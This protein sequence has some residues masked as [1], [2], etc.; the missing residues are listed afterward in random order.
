MADVS[1]PGDNPLRASP[2][3]ASVSSPALQDLLDGAEERHF[4]AGAVM[5]RQGGPGDGLLI[6]LDGQAHATLR[7]RDGDHLLARFD[8]GAVVGEMALVTREA[9]SADV[10][11][12]SAVRAMFVPAVT[13]DQLAA[14]H[15]ELAT[16]L[17]RLVSDRLGHG[18]RDGFGDKSIEG[19]RILRCLGRGGMSVVYRAEDE[20]TGELV[21]LKMMSYR[22]I[23]DSV[24][25]ARF[26]QEA[27]LLQRFDHPNI[28]KLIRLFPAYH[29]YF[30]VM[31]LLEGADLQRIVNFRGVLP[32]HEVRRILGQLALALEYIHDRGFVHRDLKPANVLISRSGVVKLA[33]FGIAVPVIGLRDPRASAVETTVIGTPVFMAPEQLAG[34]AWDHR[35]D[36]YA[37]GCLTFELLHGAPL[38]S[39]TNVFELIHQKM[40]T[41]LPPREQIGRGISDEL[42]EFLHRAL[43]V[44]PDERPSSLSM[45]IPWAAPCEPPPEQL[46]TPPPESPP[47]V[48]LVD[49][50]S[51]T[52]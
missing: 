8:A 35:A 2:A 37:L 15:L 3:L 46:L 31:E 30:L 51:S 19:Y 25:L 5:L 16:L 21:A 27:D 22:L 36:V 29:T 14:R 4:A 45:L 11:A 44:N 38:F 23:Y 28:A 43:R 26:R 48:V 9:R 24:A 20:R 33:D 50:N 6:L 10:V 18:V 34:D 32:E 12:D 49:S 47:S 52:A 42:H 13:F 39:A 1:P 17:T 41:T 7:S 40:T